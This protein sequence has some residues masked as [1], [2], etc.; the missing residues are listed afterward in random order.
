MP[1]NLLDSQDFDIDKYLDTDG[2]VKG[3]KVRINGETYIQV[4][5]HLF[6]LNS[7]DVLSR[8]KWLRLDP[9]QF[10]EKEVKNLMRK[11]LKSYK[12]GK[13]SEMKEHEV[14]PRADMNVQ[15]DTSPPSELEK[16]GLMMNRLY[17]WYKLPNIDTRDDYVIEERVND[18]LTYCVENNELVTIEKLALAIGVTT[19][20][21]NAWKNGKGVSKARQT[22]IIRAYAFIHAVQS[23]LA[24]TGQI[25]KTVYIFS[26]K[27]W[28]DMVDRK[29]ITVTDTTVLGN[30]QDLDVLEAE[31]SELM[32]ED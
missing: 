18:I 23:E 22:L 5:Q 19:S 14:S 11:A 28:F 10:N 20:Q 13:A 9:K 3:R 12:Y 24:M 15:D 7:Y 30:K 17:S 21:L 26:S 2:S 8:V 4:G 1:K 16:R 25:D 6:T 27:N 29:E 31:Y 32:G